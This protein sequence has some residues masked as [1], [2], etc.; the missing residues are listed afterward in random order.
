[1]Q[2]PACK[3]AAAQAGGC[4]NGIFPSPALSV[5]VQVDVD[6]GRSLD[7]YELL[8]L[9]KSLR[10][11]Y[12][13]DGVDQITDDEVANVLSTLGTHELLPLMLPVLQNLYLLRSCCHH[14]TTIART[15]IDQATPHI[16]SQQL[17]QYVL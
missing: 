12:R 16:I 8:R 10:A 4:R 5:F 7:K 11:V 14:H 3:I 13:N 17:R 2:A 6:K 9:F 1:M 15:S